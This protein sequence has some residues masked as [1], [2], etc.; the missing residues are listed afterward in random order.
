MRMVPLR[1]RLAHRAQ[2]LGRPAAPASPYNVGFD[3]FRRAG[4]TA[5]PMPPV[6]V[7]PD[8]HVTLH[9]RLALLDTGAVLFDTFDCCVA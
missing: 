6:P 5:G 2:D 3:F 1:V 4:P 9:Y 8:S 7:G